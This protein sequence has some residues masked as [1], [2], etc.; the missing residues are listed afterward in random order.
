MHDLSMT[1]A[2]TALRRE[3]EMV[4]FKREVAYLYGDVFSQ[5]PG[6]DMKNIVG[7]HQGAESL[8]RCKKSND[9]FKNC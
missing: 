6:H 7:G 1:V 2:S 4:T 9:K 3:K 8:S 5:A